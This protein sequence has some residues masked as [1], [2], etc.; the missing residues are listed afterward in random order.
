MYKCNPCVYRKSKLLQE[1]E[2]R[3]LQ[4]GTQRQRD[5]VRRN[6]GARAGVGQYKPKQSSAFVAGWRCSAGAEVV[7]AQQG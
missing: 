6:A 1:E 5:M 3:V 4:Q 2:H 7:S